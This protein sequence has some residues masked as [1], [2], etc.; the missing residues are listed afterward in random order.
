MIAALYFTFTRSG[1]YSLGLGLIV[2]VFFLRIKGKKEIFLALV[3]LCVA[4]VVYTDMKGNR[5]SK[6]V[7]EERS[8]AGRLLLVEAGTK[9]AMDYPLLGIGNRGFKEMSQAYIPT[10]EYDPS[11]VDIHG[12]IGIE[13]PHNDFIRVWISY[14]TPA[15]IAY[16]WLFVTIFLNFLEAYRKSHSRFI[17]GITIGCIGA[18]VAYSVSSA[19]HNVMDSVVLLWVLGGL[20]IATCKLVAKEKHDLDKVSA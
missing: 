2:M 15:L 19:T 3:V 20:S 18:L 6:G 10:I 12:V 1:I 4:F 17:K 7:T 8:A 5:Y 14:G 13:Q 11:V 16:L 9:I